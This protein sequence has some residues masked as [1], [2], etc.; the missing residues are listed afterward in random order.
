MENVYR[1][2]RRL[3]VNLI[4]ALTL[5]IQG[6]SHPM[7]LQGVERPL[8]ANDYSDFLLYPVGMLVT[9]A[10]PKWFIR[11]PRFRGGTILV[12]CW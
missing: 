10:E 7:R 4:C 9:Q 6:H 3:R 8:R 12:T 2:I 11:Q 5:S 1:S